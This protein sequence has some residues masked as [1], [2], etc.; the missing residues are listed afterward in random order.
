MHRAGNPCLPLPCCH[1][2]SRPHNL[3]P[4]FAKTW[5]GR[6]DVSSDS[7][8]SPSILLFF[9]LSLSP[10]VRRDP[11]LISSAL[12]Q[13]AGQWVTVVSPSSRSCFVGLGRSLGMGRLGVQESQPV[14]EELLLPVFF[15]L[16]MNHCCLSSRAGRISTDAPGQ[17]SRS[18]AADHQAV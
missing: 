4:P 9:V 17:C 5:S 7:V 18:I 1:A 2:L 12:P 8:A 6:V 3:A 10:S 13:E 16:Q 15:V 11:S 14:Q